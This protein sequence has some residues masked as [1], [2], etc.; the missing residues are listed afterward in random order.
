MEMNR[1]AYVLKDVRYPFEKINGYFRSSKTYPDFFICCLLHK[2]ALNSMKK[3]GGH[4]I[5]LAAINF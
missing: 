4:R 1:V 3:M 2:K 5:R